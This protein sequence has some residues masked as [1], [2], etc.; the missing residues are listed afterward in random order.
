MYEVVK[1]DGQIVDFNIN[2]IADAIRKAFD[3]TQT[4]YN[5]DVI[6]FL[7]LK[8]SADYLPKIKDVREFMTR[9]NQK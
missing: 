5:D 1:R 2:K 9:F 8:V 6:D 3:A 4:Q 7:A